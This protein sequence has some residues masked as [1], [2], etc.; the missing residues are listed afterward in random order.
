[1]ALNQFLTSNKFNPWFWR[2]D[3]FLPERAR[4][5]RNFYLFSEIKEIDVQS[6]HTNP[7][8]SQFT[9]FY[10]Y[11]SVLY[12]LVYA[13]FEA[14]SDIRDMNCSSF[15]FFCIQVLSDILSNS[16]IF[17]SYEISLNF[18]CNPISLLDIF[19]L[20]FVSLP[21]GFKFETT[22]THLFR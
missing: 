7:L 18:I 2:K 9:F 15:F 4:I 6:I 11:L 16:V 3:P 12:V 22:Q 10:V 19:K 14:G 20:Y 1:M 13:Y 5:K 17:T 21:K 8:Q